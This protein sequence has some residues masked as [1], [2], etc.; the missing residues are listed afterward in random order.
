VLDL[1]GPPASDKSPAPPRTVFTSGRA[2][3][4]PLAAALA[5]LGFAETA[6]AG[7]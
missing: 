3:A 4:A 7:V 1:L 5:R 2:P 6:P